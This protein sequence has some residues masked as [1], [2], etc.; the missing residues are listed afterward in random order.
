MDSR[1]NWVYLLGIPKSREVLWV[2]E[3]F[4]V[5]HRTAGVRSSCLFRRLEV[6]KDVR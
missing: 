4:P 1:Q 2:G 6:E 3:G 5:E